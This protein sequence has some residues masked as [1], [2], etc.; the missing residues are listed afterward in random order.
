[1]ELRRIKVNADKLPDSWMLPDYQELRI[2]PLG[3]IQYG[4]DLD[5]RRLSGYVKWAKR[6]D[7]RI[8]GMGDYVDF[9][10]PSGRTRIATA[11]AGAYE[12]EVSATDRAATEDVNSIFNILEPL[13]GRFYGLIRGH[14][15]CQFSGDKGD[16]T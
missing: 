3:D 6:I 2:L 13:E 5:V 11:Q 14:H 9:A 8:V 7:A 1:M 4:P 16:S 15:W 12:S 10:S